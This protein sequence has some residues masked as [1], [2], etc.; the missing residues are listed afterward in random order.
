MI[1]DSKV[2]IPQRIVS[3]LFG[4]NFSFF[5]TGS[6]W[7]MCERPDSDWDFM[8]QDTPAVRDYLTS[9]GF[10]SHWEGTENEYKRDTF[11][12]DCWALDDIQIQLVNDVHLK[13][14]VR[15][16][17]FEFNWAFH[18]DADGFNRSKLWSDWGELI[19][20][21]IEVLDLQPFEF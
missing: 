2:E 21:K 11:T 13:C 16:L 1:L 5:C 14:R 19:T 6:R 17:I 10:K 12:N 7:F 18:K 20:R 8:V 9:I 3:L 4:N 15:D